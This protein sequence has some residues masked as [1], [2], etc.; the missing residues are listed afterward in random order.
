ML[1]IDLAQLKEQTQALQ[2]SSSKS[3]SL[4]KKVVTNE[5]YTNDL[6]RMRKSR[7]DS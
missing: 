3:P 1:K 4:V 7:V 2:E 5:W 6:F